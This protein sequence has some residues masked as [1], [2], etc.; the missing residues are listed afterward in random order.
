MTTVRPFRSVIC[1]WHLCLGV[2]TSVPHRSPRFEIG[3]SER[4]EVPTEKGLVWA[5]KDLSYPAHFAWLP[6]IDLSQVMWPLS[7]VASKQLELFRSTSTLTQ[8]GPQPRGADKDM[9]NIAVHDPGMIFS[10]QVVSRPTT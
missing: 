10:R 2:S 5:Q 3:P 1:T 9:H 4:L 7:R 6:L 8:E